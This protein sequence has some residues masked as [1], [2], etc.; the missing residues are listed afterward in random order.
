MIGE[1]SGKLEAIEKLRAEAA[2]RVERLIEQVD[3]LAR[4]RA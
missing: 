4:A 3:Q 2:E 1:L